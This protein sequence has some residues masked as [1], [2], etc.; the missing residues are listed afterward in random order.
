MPMMQINC[1]GSQHLHLIR[2]IF[3]LFYGEKENA[4]IDKKIHQIGE[5]SDSAGSFRFERAGRIN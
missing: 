3:A 2:M 5:G 4:K 1:F